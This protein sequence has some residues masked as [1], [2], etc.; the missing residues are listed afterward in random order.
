MRLA[1]QMMGL[2]RGFRSSDAFNEFLETD[3]SLEDV[4]DHEATSTE[5]AVCNP[6]LVSL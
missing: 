6:N 1:L 5:I 2:Y 4:L 3:P